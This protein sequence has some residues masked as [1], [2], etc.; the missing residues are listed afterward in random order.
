MLHA[1]ISAES[2]DIWIGRDLG[3]RGGRRTGV[4][5]VDELT[6]TSYAESLGLPS[7][8]KS[9]KGPPMKERT[10]FEIHQARA[11]VRSKIFFWNVFP[12]HPHEEGRPLTNRMHTRAERDFGLQVLELLLSILPS[13][14]LVT[15]GNDAAAAV[16][17]L[18]HHFLAVRHPSYGGQ[19]DFHTQIDAHYGI[20]RGR[21]EQTELFPQTYPSELL[22]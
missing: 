9:T 4:P 7:L 2:V 1:C 20:I 14:R 5:F 16:E 18:G 12:L 8:A 3:W 22:I 6:L 21:H 11:R 15:I 19:R 13:K 10:A 17:H